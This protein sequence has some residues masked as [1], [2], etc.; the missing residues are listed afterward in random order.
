MNINR[1]LLK[2]RFDEGNGVLTQLPGVL[3]T[4]T[5]LKTDRRDRFHDLPISA[6][7][8][9]RIA[10]VKGVLVL[11][12]PGCGYMCSTDKGAYID[13]LVE[14]EDPSF[15]AAKKN[16][17]TWSGIYPDEFK[18]SDIDINIFRNGRSLTLQEI[19]TIVRHHPSNIKGTN[20]LV[21]DD[22]DGIKF[23]VDIYPYKKESIFE[24]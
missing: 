20:L 4:Y 19:N 10:V 2:Q 3:D 12:F 18:L 13:A 24:I 21:L 6:R 15:W 11:L 16:K 9:A 7:F 5:Q 23:K 1:E 8:S 17:K 22:L 14:S